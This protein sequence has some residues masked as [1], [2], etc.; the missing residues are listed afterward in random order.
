MKLTDVARSSVGA[1]V[2]GTAMTLGASGCGSS[3]PARVYDPA[4]EL[5]NADENADGILSR[6]EAARYILDNFDRRKKNVSATSSRRHGLSKDEIAKA[7]E[8][9][10]QA[11]KFIPQHG[12]VFLETLA[13]L[14]KT[15]RDPFENPE[16]IGVENNKK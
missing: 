5:I 4:K 1:F 13:E 11:M 15:Y 6:E 2:L 8:F 3:N 14:E 12:K 7:R 9:G 16:I 10:E